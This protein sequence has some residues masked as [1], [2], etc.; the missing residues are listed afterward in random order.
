MTEEEISNCDA[1]KNLKARLEDLATRYNHIEATNKDL[2][3]KAEVME[4]ER[5]SF[6]EKILAE[7]EHAIADMHAQMTRT[8]TDLARIRTIRDELVQDQQLR[9][10]RE[11]QKFTVMKEVQD[12]VEARAARI[13]SLE[14]EV[15]R[16]KALLEKEMSSDPALADLSLEQLR[17]KYEQ[18]DKSYKIL[19][20]ELPGLEQAFKKAHELGTKKVAKLEETEEKLKRLLAEKNKAESKYF[21]AMK[22]KEA[23]MNEAKAIRKQNS[24][25]TEIITQLKEAEKRTRDIV[26][27]LCYY[28]SLI[29]SY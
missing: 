14:L 12:L 2:V 13:D 16:L 26:V 23:L 17:Q 6:K 18:L 19:S 15:Q 28:P 24:S 8:E 4:S 20:N 27:C 5:T 11:E 10:L 3:E 29:Y 7:Q 21:A 25:S 9:K 1:Y 22:A